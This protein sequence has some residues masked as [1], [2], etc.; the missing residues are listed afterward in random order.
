M[1]DPTGAIDYTYDLLNRPVKITYSR[2]G[3]DVNYS[4]DAIS[5]R[6]LLT[7]TR[8]ATVV[9]SVDYQYNERDQLIQLTDKNNKTFT[10]SYD[11]AGNLTEA[12]YPNGTEALFTYDNANR[13]TAIDSLKTAGGNIRSYRY[14]YDPNGRRTQMTVDGTDVSTYGYDDLGQLIQ[15]TDKRGS[16]NFIYDEAGNRIQMV[17]DSVYGSISTDYTYDA[18]NQLL[19]AGANTY[20]YDANGNRTS[21][22]TV[23]G[24][25]YY[26]YDYCNMLT[27]ITKPD[28]SVTYTYDGDARKVSRNS[29]VS[30]ASY[31][32]FDGDTAILE[33]ATPNLANPTAYLEG[34]NGLL[35]KI[36]PAGV[37]AYYY[38]DAQGNLGAMTD[39]AGNITDTYG[40]DPWG[41]ITDRT[42]NSDEKYTYVGKYGVAIEPDDDLLMMGMRFYDPETGVFLQKDPIPG[43]IEDP[44]TLHPYMY[45]R[46]D[47]VN[48][49]DP[50]GESFVSWIKE[51][52][53]QPVAQVADEYFIQLVKKYVIDPAA[54]AYNEYIAEPIKGGCRKIQRGYASGKAKLKKKKDKLVQRGKEIGAKAKEKA[55]VAVKMA[56]DFAL[57]TA[58][59]YGNTGLVGLPEL[60]TKIGEQQAAKKAFQAGR[61][62]GALAGMVQ[63]AE[64]FIAGLGLAGGSEALGIAATPLSGG[65]SLAL[66]QVVAPAGVAVASLGAS[67]TIKGIHGYFD[68][69][70][71]LFAKT[72]VTSKTEKHHVATNKNKT[73][74]F[75]NHPSF[76]ET[77][78]NVEKDIDNLVQLANQ[79]GR[80]TN[81]Y[82]QEVWD[83]LN[84]VYNR[85]GG[86][87][88]LEAAVR[89]ELQTMK[90]ELI[91]GSLNPYGK[92]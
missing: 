70:D 5:N 72:E 1:A 41:A 25:V 56:K 77:G 88:K 68:A 21:K 9:Y 2:N 46:N 89:K 74:D 73:F 10:F 40:Y 71:R 34:F 39:D 18:A 44:T 61:M 26:A 23:S 58:Y 59:E 8:G 24:T 42:G 29:T 27:G 45:T 75:K 60:A 32:L 19:T 22:T 81:T 11:N 16:F 67:Q 14:A 4:Y 55:V 48:K 3:L 79:K 91:N 90:Q 50:T 85:Y 63:G 64:T 78:I 37:I 76:K 6:T 28:G 49:I 35:A 33:G 87:D 30:G 80:H 13:V 38:H 66:A 43:F 17:A 15:V 82:H 52:V 92:K 12:A 83:R 20:T 7:V 47:P 31:F 54:K 36:T 51:N 69:G 53:V 86:T 57:G 65:S 84:A 62:A